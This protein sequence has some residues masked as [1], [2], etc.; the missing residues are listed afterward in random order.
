[1]GEG[2][3]KDTGKVFSSHGISLTSMPSLSPMGNIT[4]CEMGGTPYKLGVYAIGIILP[5]W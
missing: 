3:N 2:I 4:D 1:M 5:I